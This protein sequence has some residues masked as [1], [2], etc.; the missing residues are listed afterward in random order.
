MWPL[1]DYLVIDTLDHEL[2]FTGCSATEPTPLSRRLTLY[3]QPPPGI[4]PAR[5]KF[6]GA[7]EVS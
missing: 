7:H 5:T 6:R 2:S 3:W 1:R 4:L